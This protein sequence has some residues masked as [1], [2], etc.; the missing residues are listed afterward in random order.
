SKK[1]GELGDLDLNG[2]HKEVNRI[3]HR[4]AQQDSDNSAATAEYQSL[5]QEFYEQHP[6]I[7]SYRFLDS[8]F[9]SSL[10]DGDEH[11]IHDADSAGDQG[12]SSDDQE[13]QG[14]PQAD[15]AGSLQD[16]RKIIDL[17]DG[18]SS[19]AINKQLPDFRRQCRD[20][21]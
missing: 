9:A 8:D 1:D 13:H 19:V 21:V 7:G 10:S 3:G 6:S 11:N 4:N 16:F 12:N 15:P 2:W 18:L 5:S 20:G 14:K 17:I